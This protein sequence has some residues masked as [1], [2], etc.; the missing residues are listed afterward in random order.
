MNI[1]LWVV[2]IVVAL[3]FGLTGVAKL[4]MPV[5]KLA[6]MWAWPGQYPTMVRI[7][8]LIDLAGGLGVIL[9]SLTR[10]APKLTIWAATG[11]VL[12]QLCA[13][14]FHVSRGEAFVTPINFIALSLAAFIAWGRSSRVPI[15][16]R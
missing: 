14:G 9:P 5:E 2:Q 6:D 4:G 16:P 7:T 13:V 11:C 12:L 15:A 1:L 3:F 10:I 8:G